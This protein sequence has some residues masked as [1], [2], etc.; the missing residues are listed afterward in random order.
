[1]AEKILP[2]NAR[3]FENL[4]FT[5][6][7]EGDFL[8]EDVDGIFW[9]ESLR[10]EFSDAPWE[11]VRIDRSQSP[12]VAPLLTQIQFAACVS[13]GKKNGGKVF[14]KLKDGTRLLAYEPDRRRPNGDLQGTLTLVVRIS[15]GTRR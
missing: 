12:R 13:R 5:V 4:R 14:L 15:R 3:M 8:Q 2:I 6:V 1:M 9:L 7:F 10:N 11:A